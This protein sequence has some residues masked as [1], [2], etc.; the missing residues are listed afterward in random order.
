MKE[1][2]SEATHDRILLKFQLKIKETWSAAA[3]RRMWLIFIQIPIENERK[4][5]GGTSSQNLEAFLAEAL[6]TIGKNQKNQ[7]N[8]SYV[9]K[10]FKKRWKKPK[11]PKKP[12]FFAKWE[13]AQILS[14]V[15]RLS[16]FAKN[17]G[18]FVFFSFSEGF[19]K[20]FLT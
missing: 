18:F 13:S 1:N 19:L 20:V 11:K 15:T 3:V 17:F 9:S 10:T 4:F 2:W 7:K 16:H 14:P 5:V 6:K 8:Q 12:K